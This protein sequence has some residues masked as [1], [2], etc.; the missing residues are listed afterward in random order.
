MLVIRKFL[1][2]SK[3]PI[4]VKAD[5]LA[6]GKGVFICKNKTE[7][8]K[9]TTEIFKGK[10][11]GRSI[12]FVKTIGT[13][14]LKDSVK[15]SIFNI[16]SHSKKFKINLKEFKNRNI[17]DENFFLY[18]EEFDLC[19]SLIDLGKNIF[20]AK[21]LKIHHLGF[22]S[23]LNEKKEDN[24]KMIKLRDWHYMWSSFYFYKKNYS[25]VYAFKKFF[26]KFLSSLLKIIF[27]SIIFQ[28]IHRDK[29]LYRFLGLLNSMLG[30]S[31]NY[32]G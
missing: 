32:R 12:E 27:Y 11:K 16:L 17:F 4:V 7:V 23:S 2:E 19:K 24:L 15:E 13:R 14:P 29:Y 20:T 8:L 3:L 31:S 25:Y 21:K 10:F 5:G 26:G 6:A 1:K 9:I 18:F 22:K 28:K 30:K